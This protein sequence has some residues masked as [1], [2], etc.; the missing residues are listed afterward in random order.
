MWAAENYAPGLIAISESAGD[1]PLQSRRPKWRRLCR[2]LG[3]LAIL[4]IIGVGLCVVIA[5]TVAQPVGYAS[6]EYLLISSPIVIPGLLSLY[7]CTRHCCGLILNFVFAFL[8]LLVGG[9][10]IATGTLNAIG[11]MLM[12][13]GGLILT[14]ILSS[15]VYNRCTGGEE[16]EEG[17]LGSRQRSFRRRAGDLLF[18]DDVSQRAY[19]NCAPLRRSFRLGSQKKKLPEPEVQFIVPELPP[20]SSGLHSRRDSPELNRGTLGL[21]EFA[22]LDGHPRSHQGMSVAS[23]TETNSPSAASR[24][25]VATGSS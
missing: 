16:D 6:W 25:F 11:I 22:T 23:T 24:T 20:P 12:I 10:L 4:S 3:A 14:V 21:Q 9:V 15:L 1:D 13:V 18:G 17:E 2:Y 7:L 19:P 5:L 8:A